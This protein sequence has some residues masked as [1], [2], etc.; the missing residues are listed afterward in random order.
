MDGNP[1][2]MRYN[3]LVYSSGDG[4]YPI[5]AHCLELDVIGTGKSV[6][7]ALDQLVELIELQL[8][9][10]AKEGIDLE[11]PASPEIQ[12]RYLAAQKAGRRIARELVERVLADAKKRRG[13]K[14]PGFTNVIATV[15][16]PGE[17]L[18]YA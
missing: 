14:A 10:S 1:K 16:I 3:V 2:S 5:A 9:V 13:H 8:E 7:A 12:E 11:F 17:Y 18:N 4:R 15:D 6:Q